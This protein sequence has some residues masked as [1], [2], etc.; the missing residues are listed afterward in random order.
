MR[1]HSILP[2]MTETKRR[3]HQVLGTKWDNSYA[4]G[5]SVKLNNSDIPF[6]SICPREM[7]T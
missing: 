6:L 2:M 4:T 3:E 1:Y 7:K 5:G